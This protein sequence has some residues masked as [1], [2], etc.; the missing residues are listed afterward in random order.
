MI[1]QLPQLHLSHQQILFGYNAYWWPSIRYMAPALTL[2]LTG[3]VLRPLHRAIL[4]KI[5]VNCNSPKLA[6]PVSPAA[7]GLGH[8]SLELEQGLER[9]SHMAS[10]WSSP[11]PSDPLLR[12]SLKLLQL[13]VGSSALVLHLPFKRHTPLSTSCWFTSVWDFCSEY[14]IFPQLPGVVLPKSSC[15]NNKAR[16]DVAL[17]CSSFTQF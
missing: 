6:I 3:N 17:Q 11:T 13:E 7:G 16:M 2:P 9:L 10:L 14:H 1:F 8:K 15:S 4:P 12:T 5:G